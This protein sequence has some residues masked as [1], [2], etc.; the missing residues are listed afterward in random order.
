MS[1]QTGHWDSVYRDRAETDVSWYEPRP[2]TSLRLIADAGVSHTAPV[3]DIGGGASRLAEALFAEGY[4]DLTVLDLSPHALARAATRLPEGAPVEWIAGNVLAW[5]PARQYALWHDRAAFHFLTDPFDQG[6][7][8]QTLAA[9]LAPGGHAVI[10]TF[11]PEG[12][13]RCSG[14]PVARWDGPALAAHFGPGFELAVSERHAH[15][16]PGGVVQ[17]FHYGVLRR[18]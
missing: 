16:T 9:A 12:P 1:E 4:S 5:A 18:L 7:Y 15:T 10:A 17:R 3:I 13:D 14:L 8:A 2:E 6:R 11:A